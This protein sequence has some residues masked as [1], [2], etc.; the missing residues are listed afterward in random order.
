M[1]GTFVISRRAFAASLLATAALGIGV[2]ELAA[3]LAPS[4]AHAVTAAVPPSCGKFAQN[5]GHALTYLGT[6]LEDAAKYPPL[7]P[8]AISAGEARSSA[9]V[10]Q[11]TSALKTINAAISSQ[12]A[13]FNAVKGPLLS[14]E[15][16]CL[17]G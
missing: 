11:I 16:S 9:K 7:I 15:H 4:Q 14:E 6:A 8:K 10:G 12:G 2:G 13:K 1:A 17:G 3:P 5:V